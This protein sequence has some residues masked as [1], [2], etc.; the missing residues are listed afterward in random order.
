VFDQ[1][2]APAMPEHV[3]P[4]EFPDGSNPSVQ[5]TDSPCGKLRV[6]VALAPV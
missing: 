1:L 6:V 3:D 5:V 4:V 2:T